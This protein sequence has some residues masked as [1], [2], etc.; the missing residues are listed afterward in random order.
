MYHRSPFLSIAVSVFCYNQSMTKISHQVILS[1]EEELSALLDLMCI[2]PLEDQSPLSSDYRLLSSFLARHPDLNED[3]WEMAINKKRL[4]RGAVHFLTELWEERTVPPKLVGQQACTLMGHMLMVKV[5]SSS[6]AVSQMKHFADIACSVPQTDKKHEGVLNL[7]N[8]GVTHTLRDC[9]FNPEKEE[10]RLL[11]ESFEKI[12]A[13]SSERHLPLKVVN[14]IKDAPSTLWPALFEASVDAS[15]SWGLEKEQ[16]GSFAND[17]FE[18][19]SNMCVQKIVK[20]SKQDVA[21]HYA[22]VFEGLAKISPSSLKSININWGGG[23]NNWSV[24]IDLLAKN[25]SP[26]VFV[27]SLPSEQDIEKNFKKDLQDGVLTRTLS[28]CS[29]S[30]DT[31]LKLKHLGGSIAPTLQMATL[32]AMINARVF[33]HMMGDVRKLNTVWQNLRAS[34][35][36]LCKDLLTEVPQTVWGRFPTHPSLVKKQAS[37]IKMLEKAHQNPTIN[38][39]LTSLPPKLQATICLVHQQTS[40][41]IA[42]T[43]GEVLPLAPFKGKTAQL[44]NS[45]PWVDAFTFQALKHELLDSQIAKNAPSSIRKM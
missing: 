28:F 40:P 44:V 25:F 3:M 45:K 21:S 22:K 1:K 35:P 9:P 6:H 24:V 39:F 2:T 13:L 33:S 34:D 23:I 37:L 36:S 19:L 18:G 5:A 12:V 27:A 43:V 20:T 32:N 8:E 30:L 7:L 41:A 4:S 11:Q 29:I 42:K 14:W 38:H 31:P 10:I 16:E 17:V 15:K 26:K